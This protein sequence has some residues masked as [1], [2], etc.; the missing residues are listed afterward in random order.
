MDKKHSA[1]TKRL[2]KGRD[3]MKLR[4][5]E[6]ITG[7]AFTVVGGALWHQGSTGIGILI[8]FFSVLWQLGLV[9]GRGQKG[10]SVQ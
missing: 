7:Q 4:A 9:T 5:F 2:R 3:K 10:A 1:P 6:F 8:V